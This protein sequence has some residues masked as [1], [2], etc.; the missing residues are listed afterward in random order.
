MSDEKLPFDVG[1]L[2]EYEDS[3]PLSREDFDKAHRAI[4]CTIL[5]IGDLPFQSLYHLPLSELSA[6]LAA[7]IPAAVRLGVLADAS[8]VMPALD[9]LASLDGTTLLLEG[10]PHNNVMLQKAS[11]AVRILRAHGILLSDFAKDS[12]AKRAA[13]ERL[14]GTPAAELTY[15]DLFT[16]TRTELE[17]KPKAL[18][19]IRKALMVGA[20]MVE[21]NGKCCDNDRCSP[22][23]PDDY[24]AMGMDNRCVPGSLQC[25][26]ID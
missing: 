2:T 12:E 22:G 18:C 7:K 17:Q 3:N 8:H 4:N 10:L 5:L 11:A 14:L 6:H 16:T 25:K 20:L 23:N 9:V 21:P 24:C 19:A 26:I 1:T 15:M 13:V